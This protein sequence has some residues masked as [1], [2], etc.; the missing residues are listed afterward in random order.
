MSSS[1]SILPTH[2]NPPTVAAYVPP[3]QRSRQNS[4]SGAAGSPR[5]VAADAAPR[6]ELF[7]CYATTPLYALDWS[8]RPGRDAFRLAFG[9]FTE[10]YHNKM[11]IAR[12]QTRPLNAPLD[13]AG[14]V[15]PGDQ[16]LV[17]SAEHDQR[18]AFIVEFVLM[19][20]VDIQ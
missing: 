3:H 6:K 9:S 16:E 17:V 13:F 15:G 19:E 12:L 1:P 14:G 20:C 8:R 7:S 4:I 2:H 5:L 11:H 10:S 18:C